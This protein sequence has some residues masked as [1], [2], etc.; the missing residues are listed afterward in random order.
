MVP[1]ELVAI[2]VCPRCKGKLNFRPDGSAFEC[3]ACRLV[4]AVEGD[5][6][7]FLLEEATPLG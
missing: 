2:V 1:K 7:N 6:P 5:I 4:F 3:A